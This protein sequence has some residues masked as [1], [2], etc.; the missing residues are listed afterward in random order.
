MST[1]PLSLSNIVSISVSVSPQGALS[2]AFNQGLVIDHSP[3]I[4]NATRVLQFSSLA[5]ILAAGYTTT[6]PA[7][8][9]AEMVFAQ[10][11]APSYVWLGLQDTTAIQTIVID[12]P[13]TGYVV[14]DV[15]G[16]IEGSASAGTVRVTSIGSAGAITSVSALNLGT[17]YS[18]G[19]GLL[20]SGGTGTG[21]T[22]SITAIGET[23][24]QA[25]TAC[26][27]ASASWYSVYCCGQSHTDVE[28]IAPF[29]EAASPVSTFFYNNFDA[30]VPAA[31]PGA[32]NCFL[33]LQAAK[34]NRSIG[35]YSSTQN[36][37]AP[38]N[39]YAGA[40]LM[41]V[42]TGLSTGLP[43]SYYTLMFKQLKNI[44]PE[45]LTQTQFANCL[46][47]NANV[48]VAQGFNAA[49][50]IFQPGVMASG[51][52]FD[53]TYNRDLL[54]SNLQFEIMDELIGVPEV[55][56]TNAGQ[57]RLLQAA[58]A[59]LQNSAAIGY[60]SP[61]TWTGAQILSI[62]PGSPLPSGYL[63]QS[64]GYVT[65]APSARQARQAMPILIALIEAGAIQSVAISVAIQ[66]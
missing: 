54:V 49:F 61:G 9:A 66:L 14:G 8:L 15:L 19:V 37:N 38:N 22:V 62:G 6:S 12:A 44:I 2:P 32:G 29:I 30:S 47:S 39:I 36:G 51:Q 53:Q 25:V 5:G 56:Q 4:P 27:A 35:I 1:T 41:G 59:A 46:A 55:P 11:P 20:T 33:T 3:V 21:A 26:R 57:Q 16:V 64:A 58:N 50:E 48:Y 42:A 7:Y 63:A 17:G 28:A 24:L 23:L 13:G 18:A 10:S 40:A 65:Q 45:P 52:F 31:T 60:I 43:G 34:Y